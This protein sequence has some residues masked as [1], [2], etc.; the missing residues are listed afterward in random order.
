MI[1]QNL[2]KV[3]SWYKSKKEYKNL[4]D[5]FGVNGLNKWELEHQKHNPTL[6]YIN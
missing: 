6:S 2:E 1:R 4:V 5:H 3:I